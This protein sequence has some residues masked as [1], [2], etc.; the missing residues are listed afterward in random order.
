MKALAHFVQW[1]QVGQCQNYGLIDQ[2]DVNPMVLG[3]IS[4]NFLFQVLGLS[5]ITGGRS[6]PKGVGETDSGF[7]KMLS[8]ISKEDL[9]HILSQMLTNYL[10]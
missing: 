8:C 4:L 6:E 2:C 3:H 9:T 7:G 10:S 5:L 1:P